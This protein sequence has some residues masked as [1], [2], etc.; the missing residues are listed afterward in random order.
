MPSQKSNSNWLEVFGR[1][2]AIADD[3]TLFRAGI[4][5]MLWQLRGD[6]K[7]EV[8]ARELQDAVVKAQL[9]H[10]LTA[11]HALKR[12]GSDKSKEKRTGPRNN[13]VPKP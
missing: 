4:E 1:N 11:L 6:K 12:D 3:L 7:L 9:R 13:A 10:T 8:Q 5:E 2:M